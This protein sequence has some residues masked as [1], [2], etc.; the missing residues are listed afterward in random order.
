MLIQDWLVFI[1]RDVVKA[2]LGPD[3]RCAELLAVDK[4]GQLEPHPTASLR[5]ARISQPRA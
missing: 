4:A 2:G 1:A 3:D 5:A